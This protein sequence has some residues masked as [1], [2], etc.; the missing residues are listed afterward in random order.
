MQHSGNP[1]IDPTH[2]RILQ[3][4]ITEAE[5][6]YRRKIDT[7]WRAAILKYPEFLDYYYSLVEVWKPSEDDRRVAFS[8]FSS[9]LMLG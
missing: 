7:A 1:P 2:I 3:S 9:N 5:V 6:V 4:Q 8:L